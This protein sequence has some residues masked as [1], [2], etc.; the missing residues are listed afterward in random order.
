MPLPGGA[1]LR[2]Y[3]P[4]SALDGKDAADAGP[5][6]PL[7]CPQ[8]CCGLRLGPLPRLP[9]SMQLCA[10]ISSRVDLDLWPHMSGVS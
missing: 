1:A 7:P 5:A 4:F 2:P 3:S 10:L 8:L 6:V 9:H